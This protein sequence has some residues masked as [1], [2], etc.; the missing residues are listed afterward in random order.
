MKIDDVVIFTDFE[1]KEYKAFI[2]RIRNMPPTVDISYAEDDEGNTVCRN[3]D[4]VP[5]RKK[6]M[7]EN[8]VRLSNLD[9]EKKREEDEE[10][11][12]WEEKRQKYIEERYTEVWS[13]LDVDMKIGPEDGTF[14]LIQV[15]DLKD[16]GS[17]KDV[18]QKVKDALFI[19]HLCRASCHL[20]SGRITLDIKGKTSK[21]TKMK[22]I[23]LEKE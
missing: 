17:L 14:M 11:K 21:L 6:E 23:L 15:F 18:F 3:R 12:E 8:Y 22:G 7:V 2:T 10:Q 16:D 13:R 5:W 19:P 9:E 20:I 4:H 1:G